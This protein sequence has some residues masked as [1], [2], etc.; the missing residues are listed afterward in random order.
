MSK[1]VFLFLDI[2]CDKQLETG[3]LTSITVELSPP[4]YVPRSDEEVLS[5]IERYFQNRL[6][7]QGEL[8]KLDIPTVEVRHPNPSIGNEDG[9]Q[10]IYI[11]ASMEFQIQCSG[12]E[13]V[14]KFIDDLLSKIKDLITEDMKGRR[15]W[16]NVTPVYKLRKAFFDIPRLE[17]TTYAVAQLTRES[18]V[19]LTFLVSLTFNFIPY[20]RREDVERYPQVPL[21]A[22]TVGFRNRIKDILLQSFTEVRTRW[23]T[24]IEMLESHVSP[25]TIWSQ[26]AYPPYHFDVMSTLVFDRYELQSISPLLLDEINDYIN[27]TILP[28][29][30]PKLKARGSFWDVSE[31]FSVPSSILPPEVAF[32]WIRI[33]VSFTLFRGTDAQSIL[34]ASKILE[35]INKDYQLF[36]YVLFVRRG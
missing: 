26:N 16:W 10:G 9:V 6:G 12:L 1:S 25:F 27:K 21:C 15:G 2:L 31:V 34:S 18:P 32:R 20:F 33:L 14:R 24:E 19:G 36:S 4:I 7:R 23:N 29:F 17:I 35:E 8:K 30:R 28:G 11:P 3:E 5:T 13:E 22:P